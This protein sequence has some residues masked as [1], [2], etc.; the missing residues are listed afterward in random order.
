MFA[1]VASTALVG[2]ES[3]HVR[4]EV[5]ATG[6]TKPSFSIVGLPDTAVREA[7]ERVLSAL[8]SSGFR[9][10]TS[11]VIVNLSPADLPKAGSA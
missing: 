7:R 2:V 10:P 9:V 4:V 1:S 11:R 8:A 5:H 6:G 3:Q